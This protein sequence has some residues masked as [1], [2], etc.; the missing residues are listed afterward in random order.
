MFNF[1]EQLEELAKCQ[2]DGVN[3]TPI[4]LS[5]DMINDLEKLREAERS[6]YEQ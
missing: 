1:A 2:E 4:R 3:V 6:A 5:A